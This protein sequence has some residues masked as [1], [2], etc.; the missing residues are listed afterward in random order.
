VTE[1]RRQMNPPSDIRAGPQQKVYPLLEEGRIVKA[2]LYQRPCKDT[3]ESLE[4]PKIKAPTDIVMI[5][6][7]TPRANR[8][9]TQATLRPGSFRPPALVRKE[10][11]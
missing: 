10:S 8:T 6:T 4:D 1:P 2:D 3:V 9:R 11:L 7:N 5:T